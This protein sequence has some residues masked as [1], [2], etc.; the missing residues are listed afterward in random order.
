MRE[1][2][3]PVLLRRRGGAVILLD[4]SG[5]CVSGGD[6]SAIP[7]FDGRWRWEPLERLMQEPEGSSRGTLR[8]RSCSSGSV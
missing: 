3:A 2:G 8:R 7:Y 5:S 4:P 6:G 1:P